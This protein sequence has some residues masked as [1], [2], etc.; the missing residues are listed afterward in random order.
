MPT[1]TPPKKKKND[2][3]CTHN[4]SARRY[5]IQGT[6][7][8]GFQQLLCPITNPGLVPYV[9]LS[10]ELTY[11]SPLRNVVSGCDLC[12]PWSFGPNCQVYSYPVDIPPT[13]GPLL[14]LVCLSSGK[15]RELFKID[16]SSL[17]MVATDRISAYDE[18]LS[19]GIPDKG[20]VLCQISGPSGLWSHHC[21]HTHTDPLSRSLVQGPER[22]GPWSEASPTEHERTLCS[23]TAVSRREGCSA[24]TLH[25]G[26]VAEGVAARSHW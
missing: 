9:S 23:W 5:R 21:E 13:H 4:F 11:H 8:L 17:L 1:V 19:N 18:I 12:F 7:H 22:Q 16:D 15:V 3:G 14:T 10:A 26:T 2:E 6:K 20:A 24:R 25:A